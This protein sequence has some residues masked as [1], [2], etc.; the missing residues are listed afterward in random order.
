[1][2]NRKTSYSST[3]NVRFQPWVQAYILK[4][5][6]EKLAV[7][8]E[9]RKLQEIR[10]KRKKMEHAIIKKPKILLKQMTG[11]LKRSEKPKIS[12]ISPSLNHGRF[13]E[14]TIKTICNQSY[15]N[16]E[17][18]VV[19]GGST[20]NTVS[21]LKRYPHIKWVS[22]KDS[23]PEEALRKGINMSR[24]EY[25]LSCCVS[26][27]YLN[28]NWFKRCVNILDSDPNVSLVWGFPQNLSED[29]IPGKISYRQFHL[30]PAPQKENFFYYWLRTKFGF[31]EGNFCVRKKILQKCLENT[32]GNEKGYDTWLEFN[33]NFESLG[34]LSYHVPVVANFGRA[35]SDQRG[36]QERQN[37]ESRRRFNNYFRKIAFYRWQ[38]ILGIKTHVFRDSSSKVL[39]IKFSVKKFCWQYVQNLFNRINL[40]IAKIL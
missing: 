34:Y 9:S 26:D 11:G 38:L 25:V 2:K 14:D 7:H 30:T 15:R 37:G 20:D 8:G 27:G 22:N 6:E 18:I 4:E 31:P 24:G 36:I 23:G 12:V 17:H 39:P 16:F 28:R 33:Y 35:H 13:L 21:I 1:M 3:D 19:D 10:L 32:Y 40:Q 5:R 29:G